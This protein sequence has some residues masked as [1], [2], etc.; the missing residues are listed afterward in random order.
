MYDC[1]IHDIWK[2]FMCSFSIV[3]SCIFDECWQLADRSVILDFS[4]S[5]RFDKLFYLLLQ[6]TAHIT[7]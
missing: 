7:K 1:T 3:C 6:I 2:D 5:T 4:E